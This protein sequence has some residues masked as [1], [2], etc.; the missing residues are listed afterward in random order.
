MF[1]IGE[2][3]FPKPESEDAEVGTK[4]GNLSIEEINELAKEKGTNMIFSRADKT[5]DFMLK[6]FLESRHSEAANDS[7]FSEKKAA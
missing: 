2:G 7:S 6:K 5:E 1:V 4:E 3:I